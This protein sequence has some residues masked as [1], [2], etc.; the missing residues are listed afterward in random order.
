MRSGVSLVEVLIA[1][2]IVG[3]AV[4]TLYQVFG[5]GAVVADRSGM[6]FL[7]AQLGR[8]TIEELRALP[9][10]DLDALARD[11]DLL[12]K[13]PKHP[14]AGM[15]KLGRMKTLATD[16]VFAATD[17]RYPDIYRRFTI[18]RLIVARTPAPGDVERHYE[19]VVRVTWTESGE[20]R[21]G[22]ADTTF[23]AVITAGVQ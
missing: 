14:L 8:E 12:D 5:R 21:S 19:A 18:T 17:L 7:A 6:A 1:A 11:P 16:P 15:L 9:P 23:R 22:P 3:G 2:V 10:A 20:T 4:L 13:E